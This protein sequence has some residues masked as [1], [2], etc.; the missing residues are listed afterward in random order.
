L[1]GTVYFNSQTITLTSGHALTLRGNVTG[2]VTL[3]GGPL[4]FG[5]AGSQY[6]VSDI[7]VN[8]LVTV[9]QGAVLQAGGSSRTLTVNGDV[10]NNGTI[11]DN[12]N[13]Y[14]NISG[15]ITNNGTWTNERTYLTGT[16]PRTIEGTVPISGTIQ[17]NNSFTIIN[18]PILG[19]TVYFNSQTIT[20]T[21]GHA[22]TL[23]GNV[24]GSVTLLGGPLIFGAAGSQYIVSDITVN[25]LVTVAQGAV[26]QAG[27]SSRT[28]TVNG[29]VINN[30][31][32]TDNYNLY[33]NISG[34][35]TN[36]G[37]WTNERTYVTWPTVNGADYYEFS[38]TGQNTVQVSGT[39]YDI[40]DYLALQD[41]ILYWQVRAIVGGTPTD[42]SEIKRIILHYNVAILVHPMAYAF[43]VVD[44]GSQSPAQAFTITNTGNLDIDI[45][46]LSLT[47]TDAAEFSITSNNCSNQV[48]TPTNNCTVEVVFAPNTTG[49]KQATLLI[50]SNAP[51]TLEIALVGGLE[52]LSGVLQFSVDNVS[53]N[54]D[55]GSAT[56]TVT[57]TNGSNGAISVDYASTNNSATAGND[58]IAA[59]GTLNWN[60]GDASAKTFT[61]TI[62]DD[63]T[64]EGNETLD[65]SLGNVTGGAVLGVP[66]T[67]A[68][69]IMDNDSGESIKNDV[70]IDFGPS[71]GIYARLN[72]NSWV[73][74][75]SSS[76]NSMVTGDLDG[77][78]QDEVIID[79]GTPDGILLLM[80]NSAWV[81]LHSLSPDSM[82]TVDIDDN[83]QNDI[84][85]DFGAQNGIWQLMNNND[86]VSLHSLS[87]ES[88]VTGDIDGYRQDVIIDF[89]PGNGI[90]LWMN[91]SAW[92][93]LH[94]LSPED[95]VTG[96]LD[97]NGQDEVILD[98]GPGVGIWLRMNNWAWVQLH[99]LSPEDMVT[100][101]LD[102]NGQDE[103]IIDFGPGVGIWQWM[104]NSTWVQL[105]SLSPEDMVT[106]DLDGNDQDDVII[107]FGSSVGIWLRMNNSTW[108]Q[109]HSLSSVNMVTGNID[110]QSVAS[111]QVQSD[112]TMLLPEAEAVLP[113]AEQTVLPPSE[114]EEL[115]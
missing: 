84:I 91:N 93:Q 55:G 64:V 87:P 5:A 42:W 30:G 70:I 85:I 110:G 79:F 43:D 6:I 63:D 13:L 7:T 23:R 2:S 113:E 33:L 81:Q 67:A 88:M 115:P 82:V 73:L 40:S 16:E 60:D 76:A 111:H 104:N 41:T 47:G 18:S 29:D 32:I 20:L 35:I 51:E 1:G 34:N 9:A 112:N 14:L 72:N 11:T 38:I 103:V 86:W 39:Y 65:L 89:G 31:T 80:N 101:D 71:Y 114:S 19:G 3:L 97:G 105:H 44:V 46:T 50:P 102:G 62:I 92:V 45:G 66:D 59:T 12:Y 56:I 15:N 61:V 106:E 90:W 8:G 52:T 94:S 37:T 17:F 49:G 27:G 107:D 74:L 83:G 48:I 53:V 54:E 109:L 4:I 78:S 69:T 100:G 95:M 68:L 10:I 58:Y 24:T 77:N 57:R 75:H 36:N 21:S 96:D 98:F 108:V 22:L 28:L 25:G 26:L 99:S